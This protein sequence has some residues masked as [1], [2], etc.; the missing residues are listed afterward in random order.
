MNNIIKAF[1]FIAVMV[2]STQIAL[3]SKTVRSPNVTEGEAEIEYKSGY[4]EDSNP[5]KDNARKHVL[6]LGYGLTDYWAAAIAGQVE[7]AAGAGENHKFTA[8]EF[9]NKFSLTE[10]GEFWLDA[11]VY[12]ELAFKTQSAQANKAKTLVLLQK[13]TEDWTNKFNFGVEQ[14]FGKDDTKATVG[15]LAWS[16]KYHLIPEFQPGFEYHANFGEIRES[17]P[18]ENQSHQLGPVFYGSL[19]YGFGY[20]IGYLF[21]LSDKAPDGE[22]KAIIGYEF[23]F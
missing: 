6:E 11:G 10:K 22:L 15:I 20:D 1:V 14:E 17:E 13:K 21:G 19:P 12:L 16:T 8:I 4:I 3:A 9:E 7:S 5:A 23:H 18:W 2:L